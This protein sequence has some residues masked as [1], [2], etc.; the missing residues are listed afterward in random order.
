MRI[1]IMLGLAM[2]L[3]SHAQAGLAASVIKDG[4]F[5]Q[6]QFTNDGNGYMELS[7]GSTT[8]LGWTVSTSNGDIVWAS[9]SN[10]DHISP[11]SGKY[12]I[13]LTGLGNDATNGA[14]S[15]AIHVKPGVTYAF[16][17]DAASFNDALPVVT[18]GDQDV[19]LTAGTPFTVK[20]TSWTPLT[21]TFTAVKGNKTPILTIENTT[22]GAE[23]VFIDNVRITAQ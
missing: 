10:V 14:V 19:T 11:S 18:V 4:S 15:Q 17:V 9:K 16:A 13:D 3:T 21:G 20:G 1:F 2:F 5:E 22:A 12:C 7:N 8:I 23:L 6:G